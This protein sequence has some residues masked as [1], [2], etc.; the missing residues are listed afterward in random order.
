MLCG[1][2][3][4]DGKWVWWVW[5]AGAVDGYSRLL[6]C[7]NSIYNSWRMIWL[8]SH[9]S[10]MGGENVD[11][12]AHPYGI[13]KRWR[14]GS[15]LTGRSIHNVFADS[16]SLFYHLFYFMESRGI[17][18]CENPEHLNYVYT[19]RN[20]FFCLEYSSYKNRNKFKFIVGCRILALII[21]QFVN[22]WV[23][24]STAS[25]S[26]SDII[27]IPLF[28]LSTVDKQFDVQVI[29]M[30][31][32]VPWVVARQCLRMRSEVNMFRT[33]KWKWTGRWMSYVKCSIRLICD[34]RSASVW[35]RVWRRPSCEN[36]QKNL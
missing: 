33:H 10:D 17:L 3:H 26:E 14:S 32:R 30:N 21:Y 19:T 22:C 25:E 12:A 5:Y 11:L 18:D 15:H 9:Q 20:V 27:C 31:I 6:L 35:R 28:V 7:R 4:V 29:M 24:E 34:R 2:W 16:L 36:T 1:M 23:N 13:V 8:V